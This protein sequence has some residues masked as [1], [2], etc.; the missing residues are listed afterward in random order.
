MKKINSLLVS[1][2]L[3]FSCQ[4]EIEIQVPKPESKLSVRAFITNKPDTVF[5][6]PGVILPQN[7]PAKLIVGLNS[8]V[9]ED[10][11]ESLTSAKVLLRKNNFT[12]D[13][14]YYNHNKE[15]FELFENPYSL[16]SPGDSVFI[17]VFYDDLK[18][19]SSDKMPSKVDILSID[20]SVFFSHYIE[21]SGIF[22]EGSITFQDPPNEEN[23]YELVVCYAGLIDDE[24]N[25]RRIKSDES[26]I[27][28]ENHYPS[29]INTSQNTFVQR[30]LLFTDKTFNGQEKSV[31]FYFIRGGTVQ[32]DEIEFQ[33]STVSYYLRNL[34]KSY[35]DFKTSK[36][37][38]L[39]NSGENFL[40]GASEPQNVFTNIEN[41][42]GSF[43][44]YTHDQE[45]YFFPKRTIE[46]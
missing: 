27:T 29:E 5:P 36:R 30:S 14:I 4:K 25:P 39:I 44:L 2:L 37:T 24:L 6:G 8:S 9:Y 11:I 12:Y 22:S 46:L 41:G 42:L 18:V 28:A 32:G 43:G 15:Y 16:P 21:G 17:D 23:Y 38:Y 20:T 26:F 31:R 10:P 7:I 19:S 35:Y 13:T 40:V 1:L 45:I 33:H 3:L 34:S